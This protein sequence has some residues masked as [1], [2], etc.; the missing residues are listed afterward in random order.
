MENQKKTENPPQK[1]GIIQSLIVGAIGVV[2]V[3]YLVNP[4]L[5]MIELIPDNFPVVG[6]LDEAAATALLISC[7]AYF[8]FDAGRLFGRG[9]QK[10]ENEKDAGQPTIEAEVVED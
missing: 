3:V 5:G 8:G 7:L 4:T 9:G 6:N 10:R 2:S 1:R